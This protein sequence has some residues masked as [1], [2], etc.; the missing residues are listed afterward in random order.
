MVH[1]HH[2]HY[3]THDDYHH[4]HEDFHYEPEDYH[5]ISDTVH[6]HI[7]DEHPVFVS[8]TSQDAFIAHGDGDEYVV[9][10]GEDRS[11]GEEIVHELGQLGSWFGTHHVFLDGDNAE[12]YLQ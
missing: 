3:H 9:A 12:N 11:Y 8:G 5:I 4:S 7:G 2:D 1:D 10:D 6:S